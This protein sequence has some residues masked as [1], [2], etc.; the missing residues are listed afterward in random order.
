MCVKTC[1]CCLSLEVGT[2]IICIFNLLVPLAEAGYCLYVA[3]HLPLTEIKVTSIYIVLIVLAIFE[4]F[5]AAVFTYGTFKKQASFLWPW[6]VL[7]W[8]KAVLLLVLFV[9]GATV[10]A[11]QLQ[12]GAVE[13]TL[14][15][16][17]IVYAV[18]LLYFSCVGNSR[19]R[20]IQA[21]TYAHYAPRRTRSNSA[22]V[23]NVYVPMTKQLDGA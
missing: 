3:V 1:C 19:R 21:D 5:C 6:L 9:V 14:V 22:I 18:I 2:Q 4:L 13:I 7:A 20:E 17:Y 15:V 16:V 8:L 11:L 10:L 12:Q 23:R